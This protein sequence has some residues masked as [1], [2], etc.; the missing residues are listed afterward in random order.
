MDQTILSNMSRV[1]NATSS[2][3]VA[4]TSNGKSKG[5]YGKPFY[6]YAEEC[7]MERK[8][9][10]SIQT[11]SN[12]HPLIWGKL[13]EKRVFDLLPTHYCFRANDTIEHKTI[14]C[15]SG[16]PDV[17]VDLPIKKVGDEKAPLT[18]KSF[19]QLVDPIYMGLEGMDAINHIRENHK[20]GEKYFWQLVS[21]AI[22][23]DSKE[24]ELIV[25]VPYKSELEEIKQLA[26]EQSG[27]A[28]NW[29]INAREMDL[30][31]L[32]DGGYYKNLN[33][34]N[35]PVTEF[36]KNFLTE[37]VLALEKL[38]IERPKLPILI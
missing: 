28:H 37:R 3:I 33:I 7:N 30:P 5:T 19:C 32:I 12:A 26:M 1:G 15:W 24:A 25:Y 11:E 21:N 6:T 38:L 2:E 36:D 10:R 14:K 22:L 4:L 34:I 27:Y 8:L 16:S 20:D 13:I 29:I 18:L 31:Y 23:T 17:T 9:G 35:F